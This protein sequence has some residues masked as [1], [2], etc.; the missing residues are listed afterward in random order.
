MPRFGKTRGMTGRRKGDGGLGKE[1]MKTEG[2]TKNQSISGTRRCEGTPGLE[3]ID[4]MVLAIC[5]PPSLETRCGFT[6]P[7]AP[8]FRGMNPPPPPKNKQNPHLQTHARS[9]S[10]LRSPTSPAPPPFQRIHT[11]PTTKWILPG[12]FF[13]KKKPQQKTAHGLLFFPGGIVVDVR[14]GEIE[15]GA[16]REGVVRRGYEFGGDEG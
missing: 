5:I 12:G 11:P 15:E 4:V 10:H 2:R 14:P 9:H 8:S 6:L 1:Q 16:M 13:L 7:H 3:R